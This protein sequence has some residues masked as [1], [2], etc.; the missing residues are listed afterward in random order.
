MT[1]GLPSGQGVKG[2]ILVSDAAQ[3]ASVLGVE[4]LRPLLG[5]PF[6]V[7]VLEQLVLGGIR[8][9]D[10]VLDTPRPL[11]YERA[12][13][14]GDRHGV[15]IRYHLVR[16]PGRPGSQ[17][18]R[19]KGP[20][21]LALAHRVLDGARLLETQEAPS[22]PIVWRTMAGA[23][24]IWSGWAALPAGTLSALPETVGL[25]E[26]GEWFLANSEKTVFLPAAPFAADTASALI[27]AQGDAFSADFLQTRG[28]L[29]PGGV[30]MGRGVVVD[31]SARVI[32]PAFLGDHA[33]IGKGAVIGPHAFVGAGAVVG[34]H[35][36]LRNA[37]VTRRTC[38][39]ERLDIENAIVSGTGITHGRHEVEVR[40]EDPFILS[41]MSRASIDARA[42]AHRAVGLGLLV[43]GLPLGLLT[44]PW[45]VAS[46]HRLRGESAVSGRSRIRLWRWRR[47]DEREQAPDKPSLRD[48]VTRV[49]P[50]LPAVISGRL[51]L[52]GREA[53][54]AEPED[55]MPAGW[56]DRLRVLPP[57]AISAAVVD[58]DASP[59]VRCLSDLTFGA[60]SSLASDLRL[61]ARYFKA[62]AS[63]FR[64]PRTDPDFARDASAIPSAAT[65]R[66]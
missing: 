38:V 45:L 5:R 62:A 24:A 3:G 66:N 30:R 11:D 4:G 48:F 44:L 47:P 16:D 42:L 65:I 18:R 54:P 46:G 50:A 12:L 6:V 1:P 2:L 41:P 19:L 64:R 36:V 35:T 60:K 23:S 8:E 61:V 20:A 10:V 40:V 49:L 63:A 29:L 14:N 57:G 15:R 37:I 9:I 53:A 31:P 52:T 33:R 51:A 59:I 27:Q 34:R 43:A 32:G 22:R 28:R 58:A 13:G 7:H 26:M 25:G 21:V 55:A 56:R 39:G 17:L